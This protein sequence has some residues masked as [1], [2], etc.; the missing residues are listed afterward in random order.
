MAAMVGGK[1]YHRRLDRGPEKADFYLLPE[2]DRRL[3]SNLRYSMEG[4]REKITKLRDVLEN[5]DKDVSR[6]AALRRAAETKLQQLIDMYGDPAVM[7]E[8]NDR[9]SHARQTD[10]RTRST[11][12]LREVT[13]IEEGEVGGSSPVELVELLSVTSG[14][15]A[16]SRNPIPICHYTE[17]G[18]ASMWVRFP[19]AVACNFLAWICR[20][21]W[22]RPANDSS[23]K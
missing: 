5:K 7:E 11:E 15:T 1:Y 8:L 6:E 21:Q 14:N 4:A 18:T 12:E 20:C 19:V 23:S 9:L 17:I 13:H 2:D 10:R 16:F 22:V 3:I